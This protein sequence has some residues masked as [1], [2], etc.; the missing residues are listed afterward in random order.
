MTSQFAQFV[1][2]AKAIGDLLSPC[3]EVVIHDIKQNK[4]VFIFNNFSKRKVGDNSLLDETINWQLEDQTT[5]IYEKLNWNGKKLKSI[6]AVLKNQNDQIF[7]LMCIN[8]D[9]S[10]LEQAKNFI[11][12]FLKP[13]AIIPQPDTLFTHDWQERI[14][15]YVHHY[16]RERNLSLPNLNKQEKQS[17]VLHL[18]E[19][20]AFEG[21][22]AANFVANVLNLSR[23]TIYNYL[24]KK[25]N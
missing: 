2:V 23:A 14:N 19:K 16:L 8:L 13:S 22:N 17:L 18:Q 1:P 6:T 25:E 11:E 21:K 24:S 15:Q 10:H 3:A 20:G 12:V 4:I 7:G 5:G 9:V